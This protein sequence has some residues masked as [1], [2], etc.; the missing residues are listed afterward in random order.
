LPRLIL[1]AAVAE[2]LFAQNPAAAVVFA[3]PP[4]ERTCDVKERRFVTRDELAWLLDEVRRRANRHPAE[5]LG[6]AH[7]RL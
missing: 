5:T 7:T 6:L 4:V 3:A 1:G 2:G